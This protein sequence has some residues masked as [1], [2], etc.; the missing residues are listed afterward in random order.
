MRYNVV[1]GTGNESFTWLW[2][3]IMKISKS[4]VLPRVALLLGSTTKPELCS[5]IHTDS[6]PPVAFWGQLE[7]Y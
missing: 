5:L 4:L 2:P 1:L 7:S 3:K 6:G